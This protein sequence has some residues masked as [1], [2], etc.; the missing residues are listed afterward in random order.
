[1]PRLI[2][3]F[4]AFESANHSFESASRCLPIMKKSPENGQG[5]NIRRRFWIDR[6]DSF[7]GVAL[8]VAVLVL[9]LA[10]L[11]SDFQDRRSMYIFKGIVGPRDVTR[12][13]TVDS[14]TW[15]R[16]ASGTESR[17][18]VLLTDTSGA[19]L[20]LSHGLKSI[21]V[22]FLITNDY[23]QAVKHSVVMVYPIVSGSVLSAE[24]LKALATVPRQ[25]GTL[26]GFNVLG[27]GLNEVFGFGEAIQSEQ[28]HQIQFSRTN[29]LTSSFTDPKESLI[30][31]GYRHPAGAIGSYGYSSPGTRTEVLATYE[32]RTA[33]II[34]R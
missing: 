31:I 26:I 3:T 22:P 34:Q 11:L 4:D 5:G 13:P 30:P 7:D 16:Y 19:W 6:F 14:T 20:S 9:I 10:V 33:A 18:A 21:G 25:G 29:P 8:L 1:M 28:H 2:R 17:L 24:A 12:I 15:S 32:D 23:R 27:G